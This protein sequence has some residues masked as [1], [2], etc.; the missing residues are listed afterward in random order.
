M[1][2]YDRGRGNPPNIIGVIM[3][4]KDDKYRVGTRAGIIQNSLSRNCFECV[5]YLG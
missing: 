2:E 5:K 3:E 1:S 4:I